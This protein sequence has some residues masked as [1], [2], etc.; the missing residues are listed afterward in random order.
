M[1]GFFGAELLGPTH[2]EVSPFGI[3]M[4]WPHAVTLI[5]NASIFVTKDVHRV[6]PRIES[7][8]TVPALFIRILRRMGEHMLDH[9]RLPR[10]LFVRRSYQAMDATLIRAPIEGEVASL[11]RLYLP[12]LETFLNA[13]LP[14]LAG[15]DIILDEVIVKPCFVEFPVNEH[16]S[17]RESEVDLESENLGAECVELERG[18]Q[19]FAIREFSQWI[20]KV[21]QQTRIKASLKGFTVHALLVQKLEEL[22]VLLGTDITHV[23]LSSVSAVP[24]SGSMLAGALDRS[25]S[26]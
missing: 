18:A 7:N 13:A 5:Y 2:A 12:S 14:L 3:Q 22:P 24:M 4:T 25:N 6:A 21:R 16:F 15:N 11:E 23:D 20:K 17:D 26:P 9:C 1:P 10:I 19:S 8:D